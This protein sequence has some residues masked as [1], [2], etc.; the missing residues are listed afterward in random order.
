MHFWLS[1]LRTANLFFFITVNEYLH[2]LSWKWGHIKKK[3]FKV[4][5]V[6]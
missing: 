1:K 6:V 5:I 4:L 2:D 3:N